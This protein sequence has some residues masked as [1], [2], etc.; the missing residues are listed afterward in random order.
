M[1]AE[2]QLQYYG[3]GFPQN[4]AENCRSSSAEEGRSEK[5]TGVLKTV[6]LELDKNPACA[7]PPE[8]RGFSFDQRNSGPV[9]GVTQNRGVKTRARRRGP[10]TP[11]RPISALRLSQREKGWNRWFYSHAL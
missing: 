4:Q 10:P 6:V 2:P 3:G 5:N 7:L 11:V 9:V 8:L 1:A